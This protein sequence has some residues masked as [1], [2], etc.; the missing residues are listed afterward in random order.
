M[1]HFD[2]KVPRKRKTE[3]EKERERE[4]RK[5]SA[6]GMGGAVLRIS[7]F[8]GLL[9]NPTLETASTSHSQLLD[10]TVRPS[11]PPPKLHNPLNLGSKH[12]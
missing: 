5:E 1:E 11:H 9:D 6:P 4:R 8:L 3:I 7:A 2:L 12:P 10:S